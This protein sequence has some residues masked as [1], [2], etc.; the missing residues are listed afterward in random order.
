[1]INISGGI[2]QTKRGFQEEKFNIYIVF[3]NYLY[4]IFLTEKKKK[5]FHIK[6]IL[7]QMTCS[8]SEINRLLLSKQGSF[9]LI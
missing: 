3:Y 5:S 9:R 7:F 8:R 1:M 6:H 2:L 4:Q